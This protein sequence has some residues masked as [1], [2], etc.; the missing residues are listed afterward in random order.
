MVA[1]GRVMD[2]SNGMEGEEGGGGG[3]C[4]ARKREGGIG[5]GDRKMRKCVCVCARVRV[6]GAGVWGGRHQRRRLA[7]T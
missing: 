3:R 7:H 2:Y 6:L 4:G 1:D 5:R